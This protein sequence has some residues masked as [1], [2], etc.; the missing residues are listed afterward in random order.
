[1]LLRTG[2]PWD[3]GLAGAVFSSGKPQVIPDVQQDRRHFPYID[4]LTGYQTRDMIVAPLKRWEGEPIG[5]LETLNKREGRLGENDS[6][7]LSII[8]ALT[9]TM[10]EQAH[11]FEEAKLAE[12]VRLLGDIGHDLK[13]VLQPVLSGSWLLRF[14]IEGPAKSS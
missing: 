7:I 10:I 4:E 5:V 1:M 12:V 14:I 8:S 2:M 3:Q 13:N 9:A 6:A 11:L